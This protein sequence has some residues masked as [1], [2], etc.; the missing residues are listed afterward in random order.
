[1]YVGAAG[2]LALAA[3]VKEDV[4]P[5]NLPDN[6][7]AKLGT[8]A[9]LGNIA[10]IATDPLGVGAKVAAPVLI[11]TAVSWLADKTGF[12]KLLAKAKAPFRL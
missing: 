8:K 2:S 11:G 6:I 7:K 4:V 3:G 12:N 10:A 9:A 1:M 5:F